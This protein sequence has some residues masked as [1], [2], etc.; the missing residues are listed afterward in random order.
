M[1]ANEKKRFYVV[2]GDKIKSARQNA[3]LKQQDFANFLK[4]SRASIVNMEKGRQHTPIHTLWDIAK[5]LNIDVSELIPQFTY[6]EKLKP[7]FK[8]I[9]LK[10]L[11]GDSLSQEKLIGFLGEIQIQKL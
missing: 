8:K 3:G 4:L 9:A 2:L 10:E 7:E 11:K 1:T 5:I 6:S